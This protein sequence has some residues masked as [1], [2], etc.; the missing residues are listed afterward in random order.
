M[1]DEI[2]LLDVGHPWYMTPSVAPERSGG[3]R[4]DCE[5]SNGLSYLPV[6]LEPGMILGLTRLEGRMTA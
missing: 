5:T 4:K 2:G 6:F 3:H 1:V